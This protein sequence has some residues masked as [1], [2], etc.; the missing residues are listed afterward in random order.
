MHN[1]TLTVISYTSELYGHSVV[2]FCDIFVP[3]PGLFCLSVSRHDIITNK[4]CTKAPMDTYEDTLRPEK[5]YTNP[6]NYGLEIVNDI[7]AMQEVNWR[8]SECVVGSAASRFFQYDTVWDFPVVFTNTSDLLFR[9]AQY[10]LSLD[11]DRAYAAIRWER[12][13]Y[14]TTCKDYWT[15]KQDETTTPDFLNKRD[16]LKLTCE[17]VK[18]LIETVHSRTKEPHV[19]VSTNEIDQENLEAIVLAG[20][21]TVKKSQLIL[22][23]LQTIVIDLQMIASA[24]SFLSWELNSYATFVHMAQL[25]Q[26]KVS[27][28][29]II[30]EK[31]DIFW[32]RMFI[33]SVS[34][35]L[36]GIILMIVVTWY[37]YRTSNLAHSMTYH[38]LSHIPYTAI[39]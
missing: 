26:R 15:L 28:S 35:V 18:N 11:A 8:T 10:L 20:F 24:S 39:Q 37:Y 17:S 12:Y 25:Q 4:T 6:L 23:E 34:A 27:K 36:I 13:N 16:E 9:K 32:H 33:I 14:A 22:D 2:N 1:R 5:K 29:I 31:K 38:K 3:P 19:Y 30:Q 21:K 7:N